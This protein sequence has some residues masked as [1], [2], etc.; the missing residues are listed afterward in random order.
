MSE[1]PKIISPGSAWQDGISAKEYSD[2]FVFLYDEY[3]NTVDYLR[4]EFGVN[5]QEMDEDG[6][7][8][9]RR[10]IIEMIELALGKQGESI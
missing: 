7:F 2:I 10:T 6:N 5:V 3:F 8:S 9:K 1:E 4:K